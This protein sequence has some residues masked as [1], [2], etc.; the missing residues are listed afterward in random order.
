LR[1]VSDSEKTHK[2]PLLRK[3]AAPYKPPSS[4]PSSIRSFSAKKEVTKPPKCELDGK[5]WIV[6]YQQGNKNVEITD[7]N[8]KQTVY[9]FRCNDSTIQIKGKVNSITLD[10]CKKTAVVFESAISSV[11]FVNCQSVQAQVTGSVPTVSI[12]KTDGCQIYLSEQSLQADIVSAKSSEMNI[13]VPQKDGDFKEFAL[14]EQY[15]TKWNGKQM[16]TT[17][18]DII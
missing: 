6:E 2:N 15:K 12:D 1:K 11:E 16:V 5:K 4:S 8:P 17:P 18:T 14:P 9:V 10:G 7:T 13:L 3:G